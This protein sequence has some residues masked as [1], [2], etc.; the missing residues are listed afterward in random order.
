MYDELVNTIDTSGIVKKQILI[1]IWM[2]LKV[3]Y[4]ILLP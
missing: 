2:R 1:L 4:L 3:E